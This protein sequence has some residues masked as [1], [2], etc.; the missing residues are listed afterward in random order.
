MFGKYTVSLGRV[1]DDIEVKEGNETLVLHVN[2]D[3]QRMVAGLSLVQTRL[4]T[5]TEDT[6][7]EDIHDCAMKFAEVIFGKEQAVK[8]SDFYHGDSGCMISICSKY[9]GERLRNLITKAQKKHKP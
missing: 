9:F 7:P 1:R 3:P 2:S 5:I 8:L 6:T 4:K